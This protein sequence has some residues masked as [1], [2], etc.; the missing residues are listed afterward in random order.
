M[1][2]AVVQGRDFDIF[3][4]Q[5]A[6]LIALLDTHIGEMHLPIEV[7]EIPFARPVFD[8]RLIASRAAVAV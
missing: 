8:F 7:G 1:L 5:A 3:V 6:V 4:V 2:P